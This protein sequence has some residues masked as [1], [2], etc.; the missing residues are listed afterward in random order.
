MIKDIQAA[1][2]DTD[3]EE[4]VAQYNYLALPVVNRQNRFLVLLL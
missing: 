3:Q 2:T 4:V 1:T